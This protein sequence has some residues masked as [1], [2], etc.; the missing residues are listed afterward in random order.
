MHYKSSYLEQAEQYE[1]NKI[2][3]VILNSDD[4]L[5]FTDGK[6]TFSWNDAKDLVRD[7]THY[8]NTMGIKQG[9]IV[10]ID[11]TKDFYTYASILACYCNGITFLPLIFEDIEKTKSIPDIINPRIY[12]SSTPKSIKD[13]D[14]T[15]IGSLVSG[16][17]S[18]RNIKFLYDNSGDNIAYIMQSSGS[19]GIPKVIPI[20][21]F[22]LE[23]YLLGIQE[24]AVFESGDIFAQTVSLTFDLSI[25]DMFLAFSNK[26]T[27]VPLTTSFAK[28][29]PRYIENLNI[30]NI[31]AVPSFFQQMYEDSFHISNVKNIFFCGEAL[32]VSTAIKIRNMFS[33]ARVFN[34]YGPTEAT[35][36]VSYFEVQENLHDNSGIVPI[37]KALPRA[38]IKLSSD[39]ELL[40][41][42][43]QLFRGYLGRD[44]KNVF[45][46]DNGTTLYRSG[47]LC[48]FDENIFRF[49]SR[50]DFQIKYRGY[51][52]ELEG[53]EAILINSLASDFG[54]IGDKEDA[55]GNFLELAIFYDQKDL[56]PTSIYSVLPKHLSSATLYHVNS[57]PRNNSGKIDRQKLREMLA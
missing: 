6:N 33:N 7:I 27:L 24:V 25:H 55:V 13:I 36:A 37:G 15:H 11:A 47:D 41:G 4:S 23:A 1:V 45:V 16:K 14:L 10:A 22:N 44:S 12:L 52:I 48:G 9:D 3:K 43:E 35:V 8:F 46:D 32:K 17:C 38:T 20:S 57:I 19:T 18:G 42:G 49:T 2:R 34:L 51:R 29:A 31:M 50:I 40:I 56:S 26:G 54:V 53:V 39:S 21:Y 30:N 28:L 5:F